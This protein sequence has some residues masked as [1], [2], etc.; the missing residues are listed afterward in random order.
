MSPPL[1][2][3]RIRY[4]VTRGFVFKTMQG[5][6]PKRVYISNSCTKNPMFHRWLTFSVC[7]LPGFAQG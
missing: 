3:F 4:I 6:V 1:I 7:G 5:R 2:C